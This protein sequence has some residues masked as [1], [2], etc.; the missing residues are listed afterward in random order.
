MEGRAGTNG[1]TPLMVDFMQEIGAWY[2]A[3]TTKSAHH[4]RI[5]CYGKGA[6]Q[7]ATTTRER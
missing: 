7:H 3:I 6:A 2:S 5:L 4:P 1:G